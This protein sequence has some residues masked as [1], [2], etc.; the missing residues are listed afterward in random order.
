MKTCS[1]MQTYGGDR[2]DLWQ[3]RFAD[4]DLIR[5]PNN[6]NENIVSFHNCPPETVRSVKAGLEAAGLERVKHVEF[7]AVPY[8]ACIRWLKYHLKRNGFDRLFFYQ[9][10]TFS[11]DPINR[12]RYEDLL[13]PDHMNVEYVVGNSP[14]EVRSTSTDDF[15]AAGFWAMDDA[16]MIANPRALDVIWDEEY[17]SKPDIWKAE[18]H[19][20]QKFRKPENCI[21]RFSLKNPIVVR[22]QIVG[23]SANMVSKL[24][25]TGYLINK[26]GNLT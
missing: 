10:D 12:H 2:G 21:S 6:F 15:I 16:S 25:G 23:A 11:C 5:F 13:Q 9:D 19:L 18:I 4:K 20:N 14:A 24:A 1:F 8:S 3:Y 17:L 22:C 7:N 26:F